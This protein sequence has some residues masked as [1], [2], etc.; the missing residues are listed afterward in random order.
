METPLQLLNLGIRNHSAIS[1]SGRRFILTR[2]FN[3]WLNS[4]ADGMGHQTVLERLFF[5]TVG[6]NNISGLLTTPPWQS[7][8]VLVFCILLQL[9]VAHHLHDFSTSGISDSLLPLEKHNLR[10]LFNSLEILIENLADEFFEI[11]WQFCAATLELDQDHEWPPQMILPFCIQNLI[12][13][14]RTAR[15]FEVSIPEDFIGEN[16]A[17]AF[18][19]CRQED[20]EICPGWV[21]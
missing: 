13:Q 7:N 17:R 1:V 14:G 10:A 8:S 20:P 5:N 18:P 6:T 9:S 4:L 11:Q 12:A 2:R 3:S 15:V 19:N 21:S 16:L